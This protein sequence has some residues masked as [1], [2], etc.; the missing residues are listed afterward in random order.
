[1]ITAAA[2]I[3]WLSLAGVVYAYAVYPALIALVAR[4]FG[5]TPSRPPATPDNLP[6]ATLL[7]SAY[8]EESVIAQRIEDALQMNYPREKMQIV[9]ASDGSS[10]RTA[11]IVAQFCGA[12][13]TAGPS[14]TP[15][16]RL[17]NPGHRRGKSA[18]LNAS[19]ADITTELVFLSDANT[20]FD[21]DAARNIAAWFADPAVLSVVGRLSLIDAATGKNADG[22]YWKYETFLK[23]CEAKLG[24]LL[25]ANGAIYAIRRDKFVPIPNH[26]IVDDFVIPL[27]ARLHHGGTIV[28]DASATAT[29]ESAAD[30]KAEFKRR[31][32]IGA[33]GFQAIT[34]LW[35]LLNPKYGWLAF[36]FFSHKLLRWLCPFFL[37]AM[38]AA[39]IAL[40]QIKTYQYLLAAQIA[41][42]ALS[43]MITLLP[44]GGKLL[45]PLRLAPMFTSMNLALLVGFFRWITGRQ[46]AAWTRTARTTPRTA[47]VPPA[48]RSEIVV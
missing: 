9:V 15:R 33:G 12:D 36:T 35:R 34:I 11:D 46:N 44:P 48:A 7:I 43:F 4:A 18:V 1:M 29:E 41:F 38:L 21:R 5:R 37:V 42:Y 26:T 27:L 24:G 13:V 22:M 40:F 45:K 2:S 8:N 10:D 17:I 6:T 28:Y 39:N 31:A 30:V 25:G 23:K 20:S 32:R 16:V 14:S 47:G 19:I 3:F